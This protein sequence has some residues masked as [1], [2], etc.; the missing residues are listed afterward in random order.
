MWCI[1]NVMSR[2]PFFIPSTMAH[3]RRDAWKRF[4]DGW[5]VPPGGRS[6]EGFRAVRVLVRPAVA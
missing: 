1:A 3:V 5:G 4:D 2:H 6:R